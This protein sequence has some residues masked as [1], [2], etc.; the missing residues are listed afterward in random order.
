MR[1]LYSF[2][3]SWICVF[4]P[5]PISTIND[6][7]F[8]TG[9]ATNTKRMRI[10]MTMERATMN[11]TIRWG[12]SE[13]ET[14]S[15]L[16]LIL[17]SHIIP[18]H[19]IVIIIINELLF[20]EILLFAHL[21]NFDFSL[22]DIRSVLFFEIISF[23]DPGG[24]W[25]QYKMS[26]P[27]CLFLQNLHFLW[28]KPALLNFVIL[29]FSF[30]K[31]SKIFEINIFF[32][33]LWRRIAN[34]MLSNAMVQIFETLAERRRLVEALDLVQFFDEISLNFLLCFETFE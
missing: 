34:S 28:T 23:Q 30:T 12:D 3:N 15:V 20:F 29:H 10:R 32:Y 11:S 24:K 5:L 7:H 25:L 4:T 22:Q 16:S 19:S 6:T 2:S 31:L 18:V 9:T 21:S 17:T 13:S 27:T 14:E 1:T 8:S 33:I 26:I